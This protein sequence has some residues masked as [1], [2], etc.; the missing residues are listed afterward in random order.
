MG[1]P[2]SGSLF[3]EELWEE[4][5]A[6]EERLR[7]AEIAERAPER[8]SERSLALLTVLQLPLS[9]YNFLSVFFFFLFFFGDG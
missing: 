1:T 8:A 2:L 9:R 5:D 4:V 7:S 6:D 3:W